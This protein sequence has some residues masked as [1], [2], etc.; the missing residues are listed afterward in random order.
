MAGVHLAINLPNGFIQETV[1]AYNSGWYPTIVD[2]MPDIEF[3][4]VGAPTEPGLGMALR[5]EV[6]TDPRTSM[7]KSDARTI[8]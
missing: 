1:R 3:G 8:V 2:R 4:E 7:R 6:F 5:P